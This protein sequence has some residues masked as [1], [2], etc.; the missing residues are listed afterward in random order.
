MFKCATTEIKRCFVSVY[1][2]CASTIS[3][4]LWLTGLGSRPNCPAMVS[5]QWRI[6]E[7]RGRCGRPS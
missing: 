1:F 5:H 6:Q 4:P 2:N 3:P 7:G